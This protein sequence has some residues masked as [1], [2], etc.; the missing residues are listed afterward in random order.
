MAIFIDVYLNFVARV[1][2]EYFILHATGFIVVYRRNFPTHLFEQLRP[3]SALRFMRKIM[4]RSW[5]SRP[6]FSG[7]DPHEEPMP[8]CF[9][10]SYTI[11]LDVS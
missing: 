4:T 9:R 3:V 11:G 1:T 2:F 10:N 6:T 5:T 8:L 7:Y